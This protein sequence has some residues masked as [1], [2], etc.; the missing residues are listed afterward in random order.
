M[1]P[2]DE[3]DLLS[4]YVD[5][6]LDA[7]ERARVDAHLP[8]CSDCRATL[9]ALRATVTELRALEDP[10]PSAQDSWALRGVVARARSDRS[11]TGRWTVAAAGV[12]ASVIAI[13]ALVLNS[14]GGGG[15]VRSRLPGVTEA[16]RDQTA[17]A[18][19][20]ILAGG[21]YTAKTVRSE[22]LG[23]D[24]QPA[25]KGDVTAPQAASGTR[26]FSNQNVSQQIA[27]CETLTF[28][29]ETTTRRALRYVVGDWSDKG[30]TTPAFFLI[31]DV[32]AAKP[33]HAEL[34]VVNRETCVTLYFAQAAR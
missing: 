24:L 28:K 4:A 23:G 13:V 34:W 26:G 27:R 11:R 1:N 3:F 9:D 21:T 32:P 25:S 30:R 20:Q 31:Y 8:A 19:V 15:N 7:A 10:I 29:G 18:A 22:L 2:H 14:G 17:S 16:A 5:G 6:E 12:A 33:D